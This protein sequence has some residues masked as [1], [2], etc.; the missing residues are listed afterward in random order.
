MKRLFV[1][2]F[3]FCGLSSASDVFDT[4]RLQANGPVPDLP[5]I[6]DMLD[7]YVFNANEVLSSA[8]GSYGDLITI[9]DFTCAG[10]GSVILNSYTCW[11]V[12]TGAVPTTLE[13]FYVEDS[14]G[15]PTGAPV[16]QET[17]NVTCT[18]SGYTSSGYIVWMA[19]L[20]LS[21]NPVVSTPCWLGTH[22]SGGTDWFP[23]A[24]S[25]VSG[26]EAHLR[27]EGSGW[28]WQPFSGSLETGDLFKIV[29][30]TVAL[31]RNT[32][33]GIKNMF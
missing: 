29:G 18:N 32:W 33:A 12:T 15:S 17:Y 5:V 10:N 22:R 14:G 9:D 8:G 31:R 2:L 6:D 26:S 24:G 30:G 23:M 3:V 7:S 25:S 19:E 20:D 28:N 13:L 16:S 1:V 27:A 21:S 4:N 11:G